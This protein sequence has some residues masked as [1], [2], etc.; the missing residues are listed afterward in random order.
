MKRIAIALA[1]TSLSACSVATFSM[2]E[3]PVGGPGDAGRGRA[4]A[5][6][7]CASCHAIGLTG[8]SPY[9][10]APP[11]R[12]I[13]AK[14]HLDDYAEAFAEGIIVPHKG[15]QVM[16]EFVLNPREIEDLLAY[17]KTLQK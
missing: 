3:E 11:F 1:L 5:E 16:P 13:A 6:A 8:K 15:R 9:G 2:E 12:D 10:G 7:H 17:L 14:G 4:M